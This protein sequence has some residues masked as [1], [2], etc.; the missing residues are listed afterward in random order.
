M[1]KSTSVFRRRNSARICF[2][3]STEDGL[4]LAETVVAIVLPV[5]AFLLACGGLGA[6]LLQA[7]HGLESV[8]KPPAVT[9]R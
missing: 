4:G 7:D 9:I 5:P 6:G 3:A 1:S 2:G 8:S